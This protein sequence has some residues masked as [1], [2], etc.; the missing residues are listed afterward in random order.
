MHI[1]DEQSYSLLM[2]KAVLNQ[3][4]SN[5]KPYIMEMGSFA[6][7]CEMTRRYM[8]PE[9]MTSVKCLERGNC[10]PMGG[11]SV[12]SLSP[13]EEPKPVVLIA[14][15]LDSRSEFYGESEDGLNAG[16]RASVLL[17]IAEALRDVEWSLVG[18]QVMIAF[19][20]G[21]QWGRIGSRAFLTDVTDFKCL[22]E[23]PH[24][25]SPFNDA[26]CSSPLRVVVTLPPKP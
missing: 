19:F 10:L 1:A 8:G 18:K 4:R 22:K 26:M 25:S 6:P 23:V 24:S 21:E 17:A 9:A 15:A 14:T 13:S 20:E 5:R 7:S 16:V 11:Q 3:D 12:W 2:E